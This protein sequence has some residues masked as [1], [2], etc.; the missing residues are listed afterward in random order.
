MSIAERLKPNIPKNES[1]KRKKERADAIFQIL[2]QAYPGAKCSLNYRNPYEILVATIL[3]AQCTDLRVNMVTP[4]LF[5]RYPDTKAMAS[6]KHSELAEIIRSTGFFNAKA[7]NLIACCQALIARHQGEV[8]DSLDELV[9]LPGVGRKTAN[10][11][12][13][14]IFHIPGVVVDTHV[15]RISR[16]LGLTK[17]SDPTKVEFDL[18]NILPPERWTLWNHLLIEHGRAICIARRPRCLEC[19]MQNYCPGPIEKN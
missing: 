1:L 15:G 11:V 8:P 5:R 2:L 7:K 16:H 10:V 6:A 13:G 14:E 18:M 3:S 9:Q 19:P 4:E 12:L 17:N